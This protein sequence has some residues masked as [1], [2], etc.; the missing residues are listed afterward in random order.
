MALN[1]NVLVSEIA[2]MRPGDPLQSGKQLA[3][4]YRKYAGAATSCAPGLPLASALDLAALKLGVQLAG[5]Y[6]TSLLVPVTASQ[7]ALAFT[8]FWLAPPVPFVGASPGIVTVAVPTTLQ[9]ALVANFMA[10]P[11]DKLVSARRLA[12]VLHLWTK[13]VV[14][15]HGPGIPVCVAPL[16]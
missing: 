3:A 13:T 2:R 6:Q 4:A 11:A 8:A 9:A 12:A 1:K 16:T 14:V 5:I 15:A 10:G 7:M